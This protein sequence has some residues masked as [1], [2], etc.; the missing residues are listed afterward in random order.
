MPKKEQGLIVENE[1]YTLEKLRE[2]TSIETV[3][4]HKLPEGQGINWLSL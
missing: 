3:N 1:E 4:W 2:S